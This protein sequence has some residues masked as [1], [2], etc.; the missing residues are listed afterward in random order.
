MALV[1]KLKLFSHLANV[2]DTRSLVIHP[3]S[4]THRQISDAEKIAAGAGPD[5]VRL[6]VGLEDV[7]DMIADLD[8]ALARGEEKRSVRNPARYG[9]ARSSWRR[10]GGKARPVPRRQRQDA[11]RESLMRQSQSERHDEDERR[12]PE[13]RR[14]DHQTGEHHGAA[15]GGAA[16][17]RSRGIERMHDRQRQDDIG[18]HHDGRI[19][20]SWH[21]PGN[22][23]RPATIRRAGRA[24]ERSCPPSAATYCRCTPPARRR[25]ARR[26][27]AARGRER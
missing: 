27:P 7:A 11:E 9:L 1:G 2:G 22:S 26:A 14:A 21:S 10:R 3:A 18:H 13:P 6:S 12:N 20:M 19:A 8:Q 16:R 23:A 25:R 24:A 15:R 5:V 17:Q 4:T